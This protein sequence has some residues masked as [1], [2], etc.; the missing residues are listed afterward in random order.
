MRKMLFLTILSVLLSTL[1]LAQEQAVLFDASRAQTFQAGGKPL[2][3]ATA[4]KPAEIV[5][6]F[7]RDRGLGP[8]TVAS[9]REV[10]EYRSPVTGQLHI[11]M[12]QRFAGL[13]VANA[14]VKATLNSQ[15]QIMHVIEN[16]AA[17]EGRR[18]A[19]ARIDERQ[20]LRAA[21]RNL[22]PALREDPAPAGRETNTIL[23]SRTPFFHDAPRVERVAVLMTS[24]VIQIG[25]LVE[26]WSEAGNRLEETLVGGDEQIL[27]VAHRTNNDSYN[28]FTK[29]PISTPQAV[30][31]GPGAGNTESPTGWLFSGTQLSVNIAGNNVHAYLDRDSNNNPDPGGESITD[32]N[33][34][35]GAD[36]ASTP[37]TAVNQRVAIQ[38]LFYLNNLTHDIL[39]RHGFV[40]GAGNFQEN[41]FGLGGR[42]SDSVNAEGQD[43]GGVDNANFATPRDGRN[44]RM[45]MYLW[46]GLGDHQV[47][48]GSSTYLAQG[49][50]FG[51]ALT[52]TGITG[53]AVLA[54]DGT[55]TPSDGCEALPD[56]SG[57]IA[58][59]D[60]GTCTFVTK[61]RNAQNAGAVAA[62]IANNVEGIPFTLGDD[63]TG[64][65]ITIPAVMISQADGTTLKSG[66]PANATVRQTDPPP[67]QRDGDVDSDIV[68]H[69]YGHGL[70]WRMIGRMS[71]ALPG[72]IGEGMSDVLSVIFNEN[73]I[74]GEY[75][76]SDPRGI[77][78]APYTDYPRTY[79]DITGTEIHF[80][81]EV[82]GAIGWRMF[83][84]F[85]NASISKEFLLDYIVDGMN[86]TPA[87]PAFEDMRDGILQSIAN[88]G[89]Q[90][91]ACLVWEAFAHYGVGVGARGRTRGPKVVVTESFTLPAECQ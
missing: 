2:T 91:H 74:V 29:D 42:E 53:L 13:R 12:E 82:Y 33:F 83:Q 40:E 56:I 41:N 36:L 11:Q 46:T 84:N 27:E 64:S 37:T 25:F 9:L 23:F 49:A 65:D 3:A 76:M 32:G 66:L 89:D 43:G 48:V 45:Q 87:G 19:A 10:K 17:L 38:N 5:A 8:A 78:S 34:L 16:V 85:L 55:G 50:A 51:P 79:G 21:L 62:I 73:D 15:G 1:A 4:A 6:Q 31:L 86:Y 39:Y 18:Q 57:N 47:V 63:G 30:V 72:A 61:V 22:Y 81:G 35:S 88:S 71:G 7:L 24:G 26:T 80:D 28:V 68:Y 60:R 90:A 20:A 69:E 75:A 77:R 58:L 44:P 70:T 14:Y 59:I 54:D 67:L 52:S